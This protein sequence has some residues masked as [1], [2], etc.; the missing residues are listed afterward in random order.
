[1]LTIHAKWFNVWGKEEGKQ[2]LEESSQRQKGTGW[3]EEAWLQAW[4]RPSLA[5]IL[6][7]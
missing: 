2:G 3:R 1:M 4:H 7:R 5:V 6:G